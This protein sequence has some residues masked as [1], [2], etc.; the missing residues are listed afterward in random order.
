MGGSSNHL[1]QTPPYNF[2]KGVFS[3][4][5]THCYLKFQ[6]LVSVIRGGNENPIPICH[7]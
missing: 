1:N 3:Q 2:H 5:E 7:T 4:G 6:R